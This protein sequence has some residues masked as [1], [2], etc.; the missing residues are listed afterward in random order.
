M[1]IYLRL[2]LI[3]RKEKF[4]EEERVKEPETVIVDGMGYFQ[5]GYYCDGCNG[6]CPYCVYDVEGNGACY[7]EEYLSCEFRK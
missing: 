6:A 5:D 3:F 1:Q 2:Y 4:M 7:K